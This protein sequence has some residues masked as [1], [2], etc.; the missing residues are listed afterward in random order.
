MSQQHTPQSHTA[1]IDDEQ[2]NDMHELLEEDFVPLLQQYLRDSDHKLIQIH[3]AHQQ[4]NYRLGA[5]A[6]HSL[7]GASAN[8]GANELA[9]LCS[10]L[11]HGFAERHSNHLPEFISQTAQELSRVNLELRQRIGRL[12]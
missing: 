2:F 5:D 12:S 10:Q 3:D 9:R 11:Q 4:Q 1:V 7:K 6:A 8:L